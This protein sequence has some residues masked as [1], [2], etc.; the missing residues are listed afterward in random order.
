MGIWSTLQPSDRT[1]FLPSAPKEKPLPTIAYK[2]WEGD[3]EYNERY[4][5]CWAVVGR[6]RCQLVGNANWSSGSKG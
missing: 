5:G 1:S 3:S 6:Q 4:W 2:A